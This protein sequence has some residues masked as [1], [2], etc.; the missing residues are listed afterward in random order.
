MIEALFAAGEPVSAAAIAA[1]LGGAQSPLDLA[2]VYRNLETLE[3]LGLVRHFHLGHGPALTRLRDRHRARVPGLRALRR[4]ARRRARA[5][6]TRARA[7]IREATG[8]QARFNHFP[9]AGLCPTA[10]KE[11]HA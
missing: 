11:S 2:S 5:R 6:S 9:I 7:A 10:P 1:G 8:F 4:R 3:A